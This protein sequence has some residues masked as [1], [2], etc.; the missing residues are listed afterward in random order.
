MSAEFKARCEKCDHVWVVAY[1]PMPV[2]D[3]AR[4][5]M[6]AACPKGCKAKVFCA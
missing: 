5:G 3:V 2:E 1:L 4:L 6:K